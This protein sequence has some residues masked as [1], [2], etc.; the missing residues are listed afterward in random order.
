[1]NRLRKY[2][3]DHFSKEQIAEIAYMCLYVHYSLPTAV[4][5]L[6]L[7]LCLIPVIGS[8]WYWWDT[9]VGAFTGGLIVCWRFDRDTR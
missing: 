5:I 3:I 2:I 9:F 8:H 6:S 1:M 7:R 4:V